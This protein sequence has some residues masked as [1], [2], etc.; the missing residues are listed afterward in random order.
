M[1]LFYRRNPL[2]MTEHRPPAIFIAD[3]VG[4]DFLNSVAVP[5]EEPVEWLTGGEDLLAWLKQA[6]L[7]PPDVHDA[8]KKK[9][10]AGELDAVARQARELREWFR[11]FV[12]KHR[13]KP[14]KP[15]ILNQLEPINR[16]LARDEEFSQITARDRAADLPHAH[17]QAASGLDWRTQRRWRTP[18]SLL[19]PIARAM[20]DVVCETDFT[21]VKACEGP[22]CTLLFLDRTRGHARRWCSMAVCGN[23]AKQAA[24]RERSQ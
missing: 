14:L 15:S 24:Y 23:R 3:A 13:G 12:H 19:F 21:H 1:R 9:A 22:T 17:S 20:G 18:S 16:L 7:V 11:G 6:G 2:D 5:S 10:A 4:L 8:W